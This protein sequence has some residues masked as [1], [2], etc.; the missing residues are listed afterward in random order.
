MAH[1]L[2]YV[3]TC[4]IPMGPFQMTVLQSARPAWMSERVFGPMSSPIHPS[5]MLLMSTT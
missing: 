5:S 4:D 1:H 3:S 2:M